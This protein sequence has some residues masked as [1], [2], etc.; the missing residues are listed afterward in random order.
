APR[1]ARGG[2]DLEGGG[3]KVPG[4]RVPPLAAPPR[5]LGPLYLTRPVGGQPFSLHTEGERVILTNASGARQEVDLVPPAV[6]PRRPGRMADVPRRPSST[7]DA[8][9]SV[10][11]I[12]R[13]M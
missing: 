10:K 2:G 13:R 5:L 7:R 6:A 4:G 11:S 9:T 3:A 8:V 1:C 12:T